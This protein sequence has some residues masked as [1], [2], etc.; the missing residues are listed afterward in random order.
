M[1]H[2]DFAKWL[3]ENNY[4]NEK[5]FNRIDEEKGFRSLVKSR[6]EKRLNTFIKLKREAHRINFP[7]IGKKQPAI[8][9]KQT[10]PN[11]AS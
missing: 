9:R 7:I 8:N 2:L 5:T 6:S 3:K 1:K 10:N 11:F 4:I